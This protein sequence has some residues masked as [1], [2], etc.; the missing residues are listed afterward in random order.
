MGSIAS[1]RAR[2][3]RPDSTDSWGRSTGGKSA[4]SVA[5]TWFGTMLFVLSNQKAD[6]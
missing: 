5:I 6:S 1:F 4:T 2:V 3:A